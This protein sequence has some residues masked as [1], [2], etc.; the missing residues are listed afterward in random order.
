LLIVRDDRLGDLTLTLPAVDRLKAAYPD[1]VIGL[2]VRPEVAP[3][4]SMFAP[5]DC[6]LETGGD[7]P[8][9]IRDFAPDAAVCIS[10]RFAAPLALRKAGVRRV[11]GTGRRWF[12]FL[13]DRRVDASRRAPVRHEL[14]HALDLAARAGAVQGPLRFPIEIPEPAT[15]QVARWLD[16]HGVVGDP[17][18]LHPGTAGSCPG[19]APGRWRELAT[20]LHDAKH[21]V[22]ITEGPADRAAM[23]SFAGSGLP[24]FAAGLPE[25]AALLSRARL[26]LGNSTGPI[27]L[28]SALGR[29]ALAI[30][31]PWKSCAAERWGPYR[32]NGWA[33][34]IEH[35]D[36]RGWSHRRRRR[37][38]GWLMD[39]LPVETV[40]RA[41][42]TMY[43]SGQPQ[44]GP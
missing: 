1:A 11:T 22:V 18:V 10:R 26:T 23:A 16:A 41:A 13:F 21:P 29:A 3:L 24:R 30:H 17:L 28:A 2:L 4:A 35:P 14:E 8:R 31:A 25:L 12:S 7:L 32:D 6:V 43:A 40:Y 27:H 44:I 39:Q 20:L 38:A 19:W 37:S 15:R 33:L 5:V 36:A 42:H 34:V 9:K